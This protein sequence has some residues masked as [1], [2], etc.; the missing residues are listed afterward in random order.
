MK[1]VRAGAFDNLVHIGKVKVALLGF[2]LF[3]VNWSLYRVRVQSSHRFPYL[4]QFDG[5]RAG[6][7]NLAA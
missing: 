3:P 5:P 6:V 4:R 7:V 2:K 1:I